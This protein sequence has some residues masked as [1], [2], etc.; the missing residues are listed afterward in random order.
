MNLVEQF[1]H[2]INNSDLSRYEKW[3]NYRNQINLF[4]ET[5]F[6]CWKLR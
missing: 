5:Y 1:N 6:R 3:S 4:L 2:D